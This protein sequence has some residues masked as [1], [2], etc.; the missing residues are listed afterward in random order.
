KVIPHV[1]TSIID[2]ETGD[3]KVEDIGVLYKI[4]KELLG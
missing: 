2:K 4:M 3:T 1:Y